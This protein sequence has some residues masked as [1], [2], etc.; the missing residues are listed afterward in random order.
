MKEN[1]NKYLTVKE[2][3]EWVNLSE[4][5]IYALKSKK[6]IPFVKIGG[7]LLFDSVKIKD[8]IEEQ[9]KQ[10]PQENT[11]A[12]EVGVGGI[13]VLNQT[14]NQNEDIVNSPLD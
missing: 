11:N 1:L 7:K 9:Q 6:K 2:L 4:S 14:I 10:E 13:A 3:S 12:V 5:H 8:W